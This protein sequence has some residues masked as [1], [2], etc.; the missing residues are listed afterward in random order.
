MGRSAQERALRDDD[1][2]LQADSPWI[3]KLG[4]RTDRY[5]ILGGQ[6]PGGPNARRGVKI[7]PR[8]ELRPKR[9]QQ[10]RAPAE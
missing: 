5:T 8:P 6:Q 4:S 9:S 2:A 3:V 10:E 1:V 7:V